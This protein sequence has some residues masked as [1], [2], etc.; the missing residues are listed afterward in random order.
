MTRQATPFFAR[1]DGY[2]YDALYATATNMLT[3]WIP[4]HGSRS[5]AIDGEPVAVLAEQLLRELVRDG[6][7][8]PDGRYPPPYGTSFPPSQAPVFA[9]R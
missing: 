2:R 8:R 5:C 4:F 1:I 3:V 6:R 7:A 9:S